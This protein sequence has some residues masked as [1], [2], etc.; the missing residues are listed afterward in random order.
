MT[1]KLFY[2]WLFVCLLIGR[3][4]AATLIY[5]Y[6][7][8][9]RLTNAAYSDGSH[10]SYSYDPA[11]N[12]LLRIR[13]TAPPPPDTTPP[14]IPTNLVKLAATP[15]ELN[16]AWNRSYDVGGSGFAEYSVYTNGVLAGNT[17]GTNFTLSNLIPDNEYC[18][19]VL[20]SD[21]AS[22]TSSQSMSL[23]IVTAHLP[24]SLGAKAELIIYPS[25][26]PWSAFV[27]LPQYLTNFAAFLREGQGLDPDRSMP[28]NVVITD[29]FDVGDIM[30]AD[31][32]NV[33]LWRGQLNPPPPFNNERGNFLYVR[34]II[35]SAIPFN[36]TGVVYEVNSNE[37][38]N[39]FRS[40]G[41]L[42]GH[43]YTFYQPGLWYGPDGVRGTADDVWRTTGPGKDPVNE[44]YFVGGIGAFGVSDQSSIAQV[45]SIVASQY[46]FTPSYRCL[47]YDTN[48]A[49]IASAFR[50][51]STSTNQTKKILCLIAPNSR[52]DFGPVSAGEKKILSFTI[53]NAGPS[54]M[55]VSEVGCPY[56][57]STA[58]PGGVLAAGTATNIAVNFH[59]DAAVPYG[60]FVTIVSDASSGTDVVA[61]SGSVSN[62]P[63]TNS[64]S[65]AV[66]PN[67][68]PA[69]PALNNITTT[70][71]AYRYNAVQF[72]KAGLRLTHERGRPESFTLPDM[73]DVGD[74]LVSTN[75]VKLWR[76]QLAPAAP[77]S[78][79]IGVVTYFALRVISVTPFNLAGVSWNYNDSANL[80]GDYSGQLTNTSYSAFI[81]GLYYG[82]DGIKGTA[83][84][85]WR[86]NDYGLF[87]VNELYHHGV[88]K[89][90]PG[91][92]K[93]QI[94]LAR[95]LVASNSPDF[96]QC[97]WTI[98]DTNGVLLATSTKSI[99]LVTTLP[100]SLRNI[101][102]S[103]GGAIGFNVHGT[104]GFSYEVWA[105]TDLADWQ[106]LSDV[107]LTNS[108]ISWFGTSG[109]TF[110]Q[111]FY[112]LRT[113]TP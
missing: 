82:A 11:G 37:P 68:G 24:S 100:P 48:G 102:R 76:G 99:P 87:L 75:P 94:A 20:A 46:P 53:S 57:F 15:H 96:I 71:R 1:N 50:S 35:K 41:N 3:L 70:S 84:D 97:T 14:S 55:R 7:S 32:T 64:V 29:H 26:G 111:R 95:S 81:Q 52:L 86:I 69:S 8:F 104:P 58:W 38:E 85:E 73:V 105:S 74:I 34:V 39:R 51:A 98:R 12:R 47:L 65:L 101:E 66:F 28:T 9:D 36:L 91:N 31:G 40:F 78:S 54:V 4:Q 25:P 108:G 109:T 106:Y 27:S 17:T 2:A 23:C 77:F 89:S 21:H 5:S 45:Q 63:A 62:T 19:S 61:V 56:G 107:T 93:E 30:V 90:L 112:R 42:A 113:V 103:Q 72:L 49:F 6:D 79:E 13:R 33:F 59:P 44:L 110:P 18:F 43:T 60:G 88:G 80:I 10:E 83:D 67:P 16:I 22:N 92:S